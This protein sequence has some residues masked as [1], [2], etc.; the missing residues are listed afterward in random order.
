MENKTVALPP[1]GDEKS[2]T[3]QGKAVYMEECKSMPP[4]LR[5]GETAERKAEIVGRMTK[6]HNAKKPLGMDVDD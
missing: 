1:V 4:F 3:P 6:S 5:E 2:A